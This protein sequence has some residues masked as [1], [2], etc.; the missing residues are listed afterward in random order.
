LI[1]DLL[2][3]ASTQRSSKA[4]QFGCLPPEQTLRP[5]NMLLSEAIASSTPPAARRLTDERPTKMHNTELAFL[6]QL[7]VSS[8]L[9]C[10]GES[11]AK[12]WRHNGFAPQNKRA[13]PAFREITLQIDPLQRVSRGA[14]PMPS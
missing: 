10:F 7:G 6:Q 3:Y 8:L 13:V 2:S 1:E 12:S 11:P 9:F 5:I 14:S 4:D